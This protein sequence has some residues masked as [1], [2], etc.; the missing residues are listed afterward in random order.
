MVSS[1]YL[2]MMLPAV[3]QLRF[4]I[5]M[6]VGLCRYFVFRQNNSKNNGSSTGSKKK[7]KKE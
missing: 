7:G 1:A 2:I 3:T 4:V 5:W 6:A